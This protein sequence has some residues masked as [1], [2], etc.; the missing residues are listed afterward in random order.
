MFRRTVL[1]TAVAVALGSSF[2]SSAAYSNEDSVEKLEKIQVTGSRISRVD[3]EGATPVTV[4]TREEIERTG[5]LTV[6]DVLRSTT[7][8]SF[9]SFSERSGSGSQS[10]AFIDMRGLGPS[11]TLILLNGK[12]MP[13]SGPAGNG[14][15]NINAIPAA[16]VESIEILADGASAV[17]G[18]DAIGGVVNVILKDDFEGVNVTVGGTK[19]DIKGGD[20]NKFS[21]TGGTAGEKGNV[22]F[23]LEHDKKD[24]IYA[25]NYKPSTSDLSSQH[26]YSSYGRNIL[27]VDSTSG[28]TVIRALD[29]HDSGSEC[30]DSFA[31]LADEKGVETCRYDYTSQMALTAASERTQFV[32]NSNYSLNDS[33]EWSNELVLGFN[34]SFGR[35]APAAD[36]FALSAG[37]T[38]LTNN[39]FDASEGGRIYYRFDEVGTRDDTVR[40]YS[41]IFTS[42]LTGAFENQKLG[43]VDWNV[44]ARFSKSLS[45]KTGTGYVLSD[46]ASQAVE[47]GSGFDEATGS[48]TDDT[49]AKMS[50]DISRDIKVDY[51]DVSGGLQFSA[52]NISGNEISWYVGAEVSSQDYVDE[53]DAQSLAGNVLGSSGSN[54]GGDRNQKALFVETLLPIHEQLE[55]NVAARYDD[56]S[57]FGNALSP[58]AS[59]R[60]QPADE[61]VL[62]GSYAKGFKAPGLTDLYKSKARSA[63]FAIDYVGCAEN[64]VADCADSSTYAKQYDAFY[65]SNPDLDAEKS[66][67]FNI[68]VVYSPLTDLA[69]GVDY[70]NIAIKDMIYYPSAQSL[71]D[72][73]L[74]GVDVSEYVTRNAAGIQSVIIKPTNVGEV[75][76][77]GIDLKVD[78]SHEVPFG[79]LSYNLNG[80]YVLEY[81]QPKY[82]TGPGDDVAGAG[83]AFYGYPQYKVNFDFGWKSFD[84]MHALNIGPRHTAG[85]TFA[86]GQSSETEVDSYTV[87]DLNYKLS[88]PWDGVAQVGVRN[89]FNRQAPL[90]SE[91]MET[92]NQV[93]N[94]SITGRAVYATYSQNF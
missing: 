94:Y 91:K 93:Q 50:Y 23:T 71:I 88:L 54:S 47:S 73:E 20:E 90:P 81:M 2:V 6:A 3:V 43:Y 11:R 45:H 1:S 63:D 15:V 59:L 32:L 56:Y 36:W 24:I 83:V 30:S 84:G 26:G 77:S 74:A 53:Y 34:K 28:K 60:Y 38:I 37:S 69:V 61:L 27:G 17:Y 12:R 22:M 25:R 57:D 14:A 39:G 65:V 16:A 29:S 7:Y 89:M 86:K 79:L 21:I 87:W 64:N 72:A 49:I 76:T 78:Y 85:Y 13:M 52:G 58:K 66:D 92:L 33:V 35:F 70:Y 19:T 8:N 44:A 40:D 51:T 10:Q 62:R 4:I 41:G 46:V 55:L 82:F 48:F 68:G 67:S 75:E 31:L 80:S 9:G 5:Q 18:S 42:A